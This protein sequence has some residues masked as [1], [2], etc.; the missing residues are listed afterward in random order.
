MDIRRWWK[1]LGKPKSG[2]VHPMPDRAGLSETK[3]H[4]PRLTRLDLPDKRHLTT[5]IPVAGKISQNGKDETSL[6]QSLLSI[7]GIRRNVIER[8]S[9]KTRNEPIVRPPCGLR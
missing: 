3:S 8:E 6:S 5:S 1:Y 2:L 4:N 9:R 7:P